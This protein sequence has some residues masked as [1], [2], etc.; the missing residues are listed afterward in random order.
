[1]PQKEIPFRQVHLDF[2]TSPAILDVGSSFDATAFVRILKRA[3]INSV[4]IFAKCH[5][6]FSYYPTRV[7]VRHPG[8]KRDLMREM[9]QA[10]HAEGI[11]APIYLTVT[12]DEYAAVEHAEWLA[13]TKEGRLPGHPP[14]STEGRWRWLCMNTP[15]ADYVAAQVEEILHT[16]PVDGF[17]FDIVRQPSPGCVCNYCLKSML[18]QEFDPENDEHL[19]LHS[20]QVARRLMDRLSTLIWAQ[21]PAATIFYNS[22][23]RV[24]A[25]PANGIKP[26]LPFMTQ[27]EIESLPS[28]RWGYNH[29][30]FLVRYLNRF[31]CQHL[32]MTGRF[33]RTWGDF[34]GVKTQAAL[35]YEIFTMLANGSKC[36]IGDQLHPRGML[37]EAVYERIGKVYASVEAKEPWCVGATPLAE[38]GVLLT[39]SATATDLH[40]ASDAD[41]GVLRM[42]VELQYQFQFIDREADFTRFRALI[43]PDTVTLDSALAAKVQSYLRNGGKLLLSGRSGL[44]PTGDAFA[45][46]ETGLDYLGPGEYEPDYVVCGPAINHGVPDLPIVQY[47]RGNRISARAGT[48]VLAHIMIPYFQRHWRH[49]SSHA[50]T[51][52]DRQTELPAVTRRGPVL[53][54]ASP[55]F[56]AYKKHAYPVHRDI[57]GNC[58]ALLLPERCVQAS[59]P[60]GGQATLL[61]QPNRMVAHLLYYVWQRRAPDLD[62]I[63]DIVP[64]HG[65]DLAV[66]TVQKP[67]NVYLAPERKDIEFTFRDGVTRCTVPV[68]RGHQMVVFTLSDGL[69]PKTT[70]K[71]LS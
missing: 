39:T 52:Y 65:L 44:T 5:H 24:E 35:E 27:V 58:L 37:E 12:W 8:L 4:T 55:L 34:G 18:A 19:T 66:R 53:Y 22:R 13:V 54:I 43:L 40:K 67:E 45:L 36:S 23:T 38:V 26:E 46:P 64:L 31:P 68:L 14:L 28:G 15:L 32:G 30:P 20:L 7:G 57:V 6:G 70:R 10:L 56:T 60:T 2:H 49:F 61:E 9:I 42:L 3:H 59:L 41:E 33:H 71:N 47:E 16:Y 29:Y 50:Q 69:E 25:L 17:F 51:P 1:M 11:R 48:E 62:I 21:Q 63:E